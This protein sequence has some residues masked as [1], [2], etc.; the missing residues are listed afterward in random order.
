MKTTVLAITGAL[1]LAMGAGA[2]TAASLDLS[3]DIVALG[4]KP[5]W[6]LT[7]SRGTQLTLSR[8]GKPALRATAPGAAITGS[9]ASWSA[10]GAD[11]QLLQVAVH[12]GTCSVAAK[13]YPMTAQVTRGAETLSGCA[14]Y[15]P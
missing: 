14:G 3:R 4:A 2:A 11:G 15:A 12:A 10:K 13:Q 9:G 1:A 6:S 8:A 7:V 5:D